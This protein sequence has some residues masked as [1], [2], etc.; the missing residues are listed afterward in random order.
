M[1]IHSQIRR[2]PPPAD[3][4][5]LSGRRCDPW[6]LHFPHRHM[7]GH[8][9]HFNFQLRPA[10]RARHRP[11]RSRLRAPGRMSALAAKIVE[12]L[13]YHVLLHPFPPIFVLSIRESR[14]PGD[15]ARKDRWGKQLY[16]YMRPGICTVSHLSVAR[17]IAPMREAGRMAEYPK[18]RLISSM[19]SSSDFRRSRRW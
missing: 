1:M 19:A 16:R 6:F 5:I 2:P 15:P 12:R 18:R 14:C 3:D 10:F 8:S 13:V 4:S 7:D 11:F 17:S 9:F